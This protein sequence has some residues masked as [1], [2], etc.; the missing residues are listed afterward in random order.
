MTYLSRSLPLYGTQCIMRYKHDKPTLCHPQNEYNRM[1]R[2][3]VLRLKPCGSVYFEASVA[4]AVLEQRYQWVLIKS[5]GVIRLQTPAAGAIWRQAHYPSY[6][7]SA[8]VPGREGGGGA[9]FI[10]R[11]VL[12]CISG[13]NVSSLSRGTGLHRLAVFFV[14]IHMAYLLIELGPSTHHL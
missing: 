5:C 8:G 14:L 11:V 7:P 2:T 6:L 3:A 12:L 13:F 9:D 10:S 1:L 4:S